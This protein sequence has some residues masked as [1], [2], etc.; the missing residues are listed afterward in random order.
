MKEMDALIDEMATKYK[1]DKKIDL[2]TAK[3]QLVEKLSG[4]ESKMH[5]T[6]VRHSPFSVVFVISA[7]GVIFFMLYV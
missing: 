2:E 1:D 5:G 3:A 6:T 7:A 4:A